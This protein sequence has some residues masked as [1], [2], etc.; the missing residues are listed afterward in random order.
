ML[1][2]QNYR[3]TAA[4]DSIEISVKGKW[5]RVPAL[6]VNGRAIIVRGKWVKKAIIDA[7]EWLESEIDDPELC[8]RKLQEQRSHALRADIFTFSQ[9]VPAISPKYG[10]PMEWQS[11]A[12]V[13]VTNFKDWWDKLPQETRKNVRRSQKRGVV[14]SVKTFDDELINGIIDVNNDSAVRQ[15]LPFAHYGKTFEQVRRD[16][17]TFLNRSEFICAYLQSEMIGFVKI[18]YRGEVASILQILPRASHYDKRPANALIAKAVELCEVRGISYLTYGMF[19]YGNKRDS[20]LLE[21]KIR[22]GFDEILVPKFYVPLTLWGSFCLRMK[23]HRGLL[24]VLPPRAITVAVRARARWYD[25][26]QR[27]SRC[28]SMSERSTCNRQMGRSNPPA[29]SNTLTRIEPGS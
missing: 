7:E 4:G 27:I 3:Q 26:K 20:S 11:V 9:K 23:L 5:V 1:E 24:G 10:Y 19:N 12:A 14:V 6:H 16:Q 17:S 18:V 21:F 2:I 15:N 8:I 22:N 13:R 29:G 28:S 25:L